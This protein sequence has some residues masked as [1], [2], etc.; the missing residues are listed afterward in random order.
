MARLTG[1]CLAIRFLRRFSEE[2]VITAVAAALE[3]PETLPPWLHRLLKRCLQEVELRLGDPP[4]AYP[5]GA[6]LSGEQI[7]PKRLREGLQT[8]GLA[9]WDAPEG[10]PP[11]PETW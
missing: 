3:T 10:P 6:A 1:Q 9:P 11:N 5:G 4:L 2:E 7:Q 8:G